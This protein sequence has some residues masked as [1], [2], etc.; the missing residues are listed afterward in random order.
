MIDLDNQ[1]PSASVTPFGAR[2]HSNHAEE[3]N[4]RN[5]IED[6]RVLRM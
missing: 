1:P 6:R 2:D 3:V 4:M 5:I